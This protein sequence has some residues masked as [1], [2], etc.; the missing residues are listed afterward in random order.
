M[1]GLRR[2]YRCTACVGYDRKQK[3][4]SGNIGFSQICLNQ[5]G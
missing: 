5:I 2:S 1:G 4:R 3:D